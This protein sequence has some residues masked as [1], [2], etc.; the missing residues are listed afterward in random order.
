MQNV[1]DLIQIKKPG[2]DELDIKLAEEKLGAI[3]PNSTKNFL[4]L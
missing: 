3:F 1:K 2:V 4:S